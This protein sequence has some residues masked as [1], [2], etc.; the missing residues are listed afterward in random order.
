MDIILDKKK[1]GNNF[2]LWQKRLGGR[3]WIIDA[4][5]LDKDME[6]DIDLKAFHVE[7]NAQ[8]GRMTLKLID[9]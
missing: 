9:Q 7:I 1:E 2:T 5:C 3:N 6:I 8:T 4:S